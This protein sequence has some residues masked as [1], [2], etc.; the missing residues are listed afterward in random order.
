MGK[1]YKDNKFKDSY[2][3]TKKSKKSQKNKRSKEVDY[4][5]EQICNNDKWT[6]KRHS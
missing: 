4:Y 1:T 5:D 3:S 6:E 2:S